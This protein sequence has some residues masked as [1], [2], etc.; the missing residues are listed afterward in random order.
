MQVQIFPYNAIATLTILLFYG[1]VP[2]LLVLSNTPCGLF[3]KGFG[4]SRGPSPRLQLLLIL[5]SLKLTLAQCGSS[6]GRSGG[7]WSL[8]A[9]SILSRLARTVAVAYEAPAPPRE[10]L[11]LGR[12]PVART[13]RFPQLSGGT[14]G[15]QR[16]SQPPALPAH[17]IASDQHGQRLVSARRGSQARA[18][19]DAQPNRAFS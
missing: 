4:E 9:A 13:R 3:S 16:S 19:P 15:G 12:P 11:R 8:Q 7:F 10:L 2:K 18:V 17:H 5:L 1:I 6:E 14:G